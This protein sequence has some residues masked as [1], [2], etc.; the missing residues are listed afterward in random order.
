[1]HA[2]GEG[3]LRFHPVRSGLQQMR[4]ARVN[5]GASVGVPMLGQRMGAL[6]KLI[7]VSNTWK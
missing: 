4:R 5:A 7:M 1:M 6:S 3:P 2:K